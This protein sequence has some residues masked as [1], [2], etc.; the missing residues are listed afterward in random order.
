MMEQNPNA[1]VIGDQVKVV[2]TPHDEGHDTGVVRQ[3]IDGA[4][5]I[6]FDSMPGMI[7]HWYVPSEVMVISAST[8]KPMKVRAVDPK[9]VERRAAQDAEMTGDDKV[10]HVVGH[11][12]VF[13]QETNVAGFFREIIRPGAFLNSI[14]RDDVPFLIEHGGLPLARN[15]SGTLKLSEDSVGLMVDSM[16]DGMDPDVMRIV[17]KMARGDLNKMS[18]GFIATRQEWD[19]NGDIP[20]RTIHEAQLF[21]VSIVTSP[22]YTGTDIGLRCLS[23][24]RSANAVPP[25]RVPL[26]A[27]RLRMRHA[28]HARQSSG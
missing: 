23:E 18:F 16:L 10:H 25:N 1:P 14:G 22:Q 6:E 28:L 7:H 12:A 27:A 19:E 8:K 5:G 11:A 4:L 15:K 24:W 26:I 3:V 13:N 21:D 2:T 9:T 20:L 17:P